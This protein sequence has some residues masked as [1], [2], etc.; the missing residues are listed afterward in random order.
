MYGCDDEHMMT[1]IEELLEGLKDV[2]SE[3]EDDGDE[4][5]STDEEED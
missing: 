1:H 5:W 2:Q 4:E 3:D